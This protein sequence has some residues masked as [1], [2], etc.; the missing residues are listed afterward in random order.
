MKEV[1]KDTKGGLTLSAEGDGLI[2]LDGCITCHARGR[3]EEGYRVIAIRK[4]ASC[5]SGPA[6]ISCSGLIL[7]WLRSS[8]SPEHTSR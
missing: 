7:E 4:L 5:T 3:M 1:E 8:A 6:T 2:R